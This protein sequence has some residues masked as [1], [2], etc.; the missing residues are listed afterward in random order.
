MIFSVFDL[1]FIAPRS[2]RWLDCGLMT[3]GFQLIVGF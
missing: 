3:L 2:L 1:Y